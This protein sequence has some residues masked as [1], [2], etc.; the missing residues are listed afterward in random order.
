MVDHLICLRS[1]QSRPQWA[2]LRKA[3]GAIKE[4]MQRNAWP[5]RQTAEVW[6]GG[7]SR[8]LPRTWNCSGTTTTTILLGDVIPSGFSGINASAGGL[9]C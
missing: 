6:A 7:K 8:G 1:D 3:V 5:L 9:D 4:S 2:R